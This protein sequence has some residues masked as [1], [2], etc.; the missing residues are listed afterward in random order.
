MSNLFITFTEC[1]FL[2]FLFVAATRY[3]S[4]QEVIKDSLTLSHLTLSYL[5][6]SYLILS[7][8]VQLSCPLLA[9]LVHTVHPCV[10][11]VVEFSLVCFITCFE[12]SCIKPSRC[13]CPLCPLRRLSSVSSQETFICLLFSDETKFEC[14]RETES[15]SDTCRRDSELHPDGST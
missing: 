12:R 7:S 13:Q 8:Y 6:L 4:T 2:C 3:M 11:P 14:E 9:S 15:E 5:I 10:V 1:G